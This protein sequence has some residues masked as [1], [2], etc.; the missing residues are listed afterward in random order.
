MSNKICNH[1]MWHKSLDNF[2]TTTPLGNV[3]NVC[4]DCE[5]D[6]TVEDILNDLTKVH[7]ILENVTN[8]LNR[9]R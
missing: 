7:D 3:P 6:L 1:C 8:K 9:E 2:T 4:N 5:Y